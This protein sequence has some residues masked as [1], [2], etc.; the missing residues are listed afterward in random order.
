MKGI[1]D[2]EEYMVSYRQKH[3]GSETSS[4]AHHDGNRSGW[5]LTTE[6][7]TGRT[8][9]GSE[10]E[11]VLSSELPAMTSQFLA[12]RQAAT[13]S[14]ERPHQEPAAFSA[15]DGDNRW[16]REGAAA[17]PGET[18]KG[19]AEAG[20]EEQAPPS[21]GEEEADPKERSGD[22][23]ISLT[24][25]LAGAG[26]AATSAVVGGQLGVAGTVM[27][28]S[29]ASVVTAV[30]VTLYSKSLDKGK[31]KI[32]EVGSKLVQPAGDR[33]SGAAQNQEAADA[34]D[35][36]P[37]SAEEQRQHGVDVLS[38]LQQL[39][40]KRILYPVIIAVATFGIGLG[41]VIAAESFTDADISPGTS[42]ISRSVSGQPAPG[43]QPSHTSDESREQNVSGGDS[44][45]GRSAGGQS[46]VDEQG[47]ERRDSQIQDRAEADSDAG[48]ARNGAQS[49]R[50]GTGP[51]ESGSEGQHS[52]DVAPDDGGS[53]GS[54]N[55]GT[56]T[57]GSAGPGGGSS[58]TGSSGS[59][60]SS[61][62]GFGGP[63]VPVP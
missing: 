21:P 41:A 25:L 43:G 55:P 13:R 22:G 54:L 4:H 8:P 52:D 23:R 63:A 45:G 15:P 62:P 59:G 26:A 37:G 3:V 61:G 9:R 34:Q 20:R 46:R 35:G 33:L 30:A 56:D 19:R 42:Q 27:G 28:A 17:R 16:L 18:R 29:I 48:T 44:R 14:A 50:S 49:S 11:P 39:R 38:W 58:G 47:S 36:S 57:S 12:V 10:R 24:Q 60:G 40:R 31:E 7:P 32:K 6:V 1:G 53:S 51:A 2:Q 5:D